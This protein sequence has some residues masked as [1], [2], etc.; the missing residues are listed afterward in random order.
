[1]PVMGVV[2]KRDIV[3]HQSRLDMESYQ[4]HI[5][6]PTS[7]HQ[8][9]YF[10]IGTDIAA[11]TVARI[12]DDN[13]LDVHIVKTDA[14]EAHALLDAEESSVFPNWMED[15]VASMC[16]HHQTNTLDDV[17]RLLRKDIKV[18]DEASD[19]GLVVFQPQEIST[20]EEDLKSYLEQSVWQAVG[21]L[22][23][24]NSAVKPKTISLQTKLI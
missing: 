14:T 6:R 15:R 22:W 16:E 23:R 12:L 13:G 9:P 4:H 20:D 19:E 3:T 1:M 5:N 7:H 10:V 24:L 17:G 21:L 18:V 8:G 2:R 11:S